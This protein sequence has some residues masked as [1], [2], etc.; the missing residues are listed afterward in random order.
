MY[1]Y[2]MQYPILSYLIVSVPNRFYS[3]VPY[4][5][6]LYLNLSTLLRY[7]C[8][9]LRSYHCILDQCLVFFIL[10][11][12]LTLQRQQSKAGLASVMHGEEDGDQDGNLSLTSS[13]STSPVISLSLYFFLK[14]KQG[15]TDRSSSF[16]RTSLY[17]PSAFLSYD[18]YC[19]IHIHN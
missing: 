4:Y 5:A 18:V 8:P 13:I 11:F 19:L 15:P 17:L 12:L 7:P 9:S 10:L 16:L 2:V 14:L 6:L 3:I 1:R